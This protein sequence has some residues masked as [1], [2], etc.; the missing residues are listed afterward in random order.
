MFLAFH[1]VWKTNSFGEAILM[2]ANIG[3]DCDSFGAV[4]G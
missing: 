1:I 4:V 3:G 2:S